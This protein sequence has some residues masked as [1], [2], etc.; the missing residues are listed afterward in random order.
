MFE[1]FLADAEPQS[2]LI[3]GALIIGLVYGAIARASGFCFRSALLEAA[4]GQIGAR[5]GLQLRA[6]AL[7]LG[8]ALVGTQAL[9]AAELVDFSEAMYVTSPILWGG[10]IVGGLAFGFGMILT[11]GCAGRHLILASGG[12][13]RAFYVV[14]VLGIAAYMTMR[15]LIAIFRME[16]NAVS[17]LETETTTF[18][19]AVSSL[20][21]LENPGLWIA[22]GLAL[23]LGFLALRGLGSRVNLRVAGTLA[24]GLGIGLL[25]PLAWLVTGNLGFDDFDP[26]PVQALTFTG[27]VGDGLVFLMTYTGSSL[28][29]GITVVGGAIAGAVLVALAKREFVLQGFEDPGQMLRYTL[30]GA[31]MGMGGVMAL[32]CTIGQ[33]LSGLSTLSIG[34]ALSFAAITLGGLAG[35][36]WLQRRRPTAVMPQA[37]E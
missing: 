2:I 4:D 13:L 22:L 21:G 32:G 35:R 10:M 24:G 20:T 12:N 34:S 27:P 23:P 28:N 19:H 16:L 7:A 9:G 17:S 25:V 29:F 8:V 15:G 31:L 3:Y 14:I 5:G 6:W 18:A 30:G 36:A 33:G 11:R 1:D 26:Q 37:A